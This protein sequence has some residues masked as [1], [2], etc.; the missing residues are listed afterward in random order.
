MHPVASSAAVVVVLGALTTG[1]APLPEGF[2]STARQAAPAARTGTLYVTATDKDGAAVTDMRPTDFEVKV[3]GKT[4]EVVSARQAA[5]PLRIA[6]LVADQGTGAFQLGIA[7]FMQTLLGHAEFKLI[8]V[9]V[10]PQTVVD[11]SHDGATLSAGLSR[12]GA[13]G[14]E[15]GAQL[16][17]AI[18]EATQDVQHEARRP[19]IV[20]LRLGGESPTQISGN[21]VREMLRKSG[22]ALYVIS[23]AGAQGAA[24][25]QA[26]AGISA[27]QAQLADS[28]LSDSAANLAQVLGDGAKE[29][30][31]R[32][33]QVIATTHARALEQVAHELL[34]QYEVACTLP[35]G[36]RSGEK[37]SVSSKRK[38]VTVRAPSRLL[39]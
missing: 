15:R 28:E 11:Y 38:G 10:Q 19:V 23:A 32:H 25:S 9:L 26:R 6:L 29:S 16:M 24:P 37:L 5:V 8:S 30:G 21:E 1:M 22:A 35:E 33:D 20:V 39:N 13:R 36:V 14:R 27:E 2:A 3:G 34:H 12:L 7:H 4:Q 31:G 17:E 18:Q